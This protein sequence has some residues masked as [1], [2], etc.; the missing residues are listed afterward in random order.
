MLH[1]LAGGSINSEPKESMPR[2]GHDGHCSLCCWSSRYACPA[3]HEVLS[4][5]LTRVL[6]A[7]CPVQVELFITDN[8]L[9]SL[10]EG[11]SG[12]RKLVK[13]Q[14]KTQ[15]GQDEQKLHVTEV[16]DLQAG[17][18]AVICSAHPF[19]ALCPLQQGC[20]PASGTTQGTF[21]AGQGLLQLIA[22]RKID[23]GWPRAAASMQRCA[24]VAHFLDSAVLA[25]SLTMLQIA[26]DICNAGFVQQATVPPG[27][28]D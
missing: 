23:W 12:L 18:Q 16:T 2:C 15:A 26:C 14:V 17:P 3:C 28:P 20:L 5:A 6:I 1:P 19:P 25:I 27:W 21:C 13:L 10:P 22:H 11:M 24:H 4:W 9:T 7:L 8:L